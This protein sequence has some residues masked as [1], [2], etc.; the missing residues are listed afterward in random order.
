MSRFRSLSE[1]L[2][3]KGLSDP[4]RTRLLAQA[5]SGHSELPTW[6]REAVHHNSGL[7]KGAI[8]KEVPA[9]LQSYLERKPSRDRFTFPWKGRP[10]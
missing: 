8:D 3:K 1:R 2:R 5:V 10:K 7:T 9:F 6:L 4:E